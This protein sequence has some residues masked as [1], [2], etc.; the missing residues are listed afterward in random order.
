VFQ[1][2]L[3]GLAEKKR[4]KGDD[5]RLRRDHAQHAGRFRDTGA[6][7]EE[8]LMRLAKEN[9]VETSTREQLNRRRPNQR[10]QR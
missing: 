2:V 6:R 3:Q 8:F 7:Y 1:W 9:R 5:G 4:I 10:L